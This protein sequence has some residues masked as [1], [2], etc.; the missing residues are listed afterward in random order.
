MLSLELVE[1][2]VED[3]KKAQ[4]LHFNKKSEILSVCVELTTVP[5]LYVNTSADSNP[6]PPLLWLKWLFS[7]TNSV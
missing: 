1:I 3:W 7:Q 6:P 4:E 5:I 2:I